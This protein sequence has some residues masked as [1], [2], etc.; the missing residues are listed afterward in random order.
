LSNDIF[1]FILFRYCDEK[2]IPY[3]KCGKLIVATSEI[4]EKRLDDLYERGLKNKVKD[5]TVVEG[6]DISK[7]EPNCVVSKLYSSRGLFAMISG[8]NVDIF[9]C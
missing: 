4:E 5:L 2:K 6:R 3:K 7:I 9:C 8:G 1:L